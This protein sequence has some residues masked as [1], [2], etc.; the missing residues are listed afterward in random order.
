[1]VGEGRDWYLGVQSS[2]LSEKKLWKIQKSIFMF[3][4]YFGYPNCANC[5]RSSDAL[6]PAPLTSIAVASQFISIDRVNPIAATV[7][8]SHECNAQK[9]HVTPLGHA[10]GVS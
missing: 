6:L 10:L 3:Y 9:R 4:S 2:I 8:L 5:R 7:Q 1:M